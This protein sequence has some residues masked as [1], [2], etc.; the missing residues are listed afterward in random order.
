M[1][2]DRRSLFGRRKGKPL[3]A[4]RGDLMRR[5]YPLLRIAS[6][7]EVDPQSLFPSPV[8]TIVMEIGFGAGEHMIAAAAA[9]PA[10]GF[11]GVEPF[12]NGM[13]RAVS[14]I[15]RLG[16]RNIRLYDDDAGALMDRMPPSRIDCVELPFPDPWPKRRHWKRRFVRQRNLDRVARVL[17]PGGIFVVATDIAD[18]AAWTLQNV[19]AHAAFRWVA[20]RPGDWRDPPDGWAP[21][22]YEAKARQA[23]REPVYLV[24]ARR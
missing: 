24:F 23:G 7:G 14:E 5:V 11:I 21:T 6:D 20:R 15:D 18:Y 22:R 1:T 4:R 9:R 10:T 2:Q 8:E 16:L 19:R 3:S 13:A 12:V 17:R